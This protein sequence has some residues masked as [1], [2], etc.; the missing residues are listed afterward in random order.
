[1]G[2]NRIFQS[3]QDFFKGFWQQESPR[4][5]LWIPVALGLGIGFYFSLKQEPSLS[6]LFLGIPLFIIKRILPV[7]AG[8]FWLFMGFAA[9]LVKSTWL[10]TPLLLEATPSMALQGTL[11][12]VEI[13]PSDHRLLLKN[14]HDAQGR[15]L[16]LE[17]IRVSCRGSL[18]HGQGALTPGDRLSL[19]CV[20]LPP[21]G[22]PHPHGY[23]FRR[24]AYFQ[25]IGGVGYVTKPPIKMSTADQST[26]I[27]SWRHGVTSF[28]RTHLQGEGGQVAAALITGDRS[29]LTE[30]T[31]NIF[32]EAGVAHILA[33]SGLHLSLVAGIF[34]FFLRGLLASIPA[35]AL[36]YDTKKAAAFMAFFGISAYLI[37]CGASLPAMRS[38]LMTSLILVGVFLDRFAL[39][40]RNVAL[41]ATFLLLI[42][43]EALLS[44]SF[45]LSFAAVI[46]LILGYEALYPWLQRWIG[47]KPWW[48]KKTMVYVLG[49]VLSTVLCTLAT[50]PYV[51]Y[52]F[53]RFSIHTLPANL[54]IIPLMSFFVMPGL[55]VFLLLAP[56][57]NVSY[58]TTVLSKLLNGMIDICHIIT[59]WQ[60]T[61]MPIK[62]MSTFSLGLI[63]LG[64]L[65]FLLIRHPLRLGG[66]FLI[67]WGLVSW[68]ASPMPTVFVAKE[69]K[70]IGWCDLR[71]HLWVSS[72]QSQRYARQSWMR[73]CGK[74]EVKKDPFLLEH[75]PKDI[76]QDVKKYLVQ[77]SEAAYLWVLPKG[78]HW[79]TSPDG[80]ARRPWSDAPMLKDTL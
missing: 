55:V 31:K 7:C 63:T 72:L 27:A 67:S 2:R 53:H 50:T 52:T 38:Y 51:I 70:F 61:S 10:S 12:S 40:A 3:I 75:F 42:W 18:C 66:I 56:F 39:S 73:Y 22:P 62:A 57:V 26:L 77:S 5:V 24:Y 54:M 47:L 6:W 28:L 71:G 13:R 4:G 29:G 58:L 8:F 30:T 69:G 45:Q 46:L 20:L 9:A 79:E 65:G 64:A 15:P 60:G 1:M 44:P 34:F 14:L 37:L 80:Q 36:R 43:P 74:E 49:I 78:R 17:K 41:A 33:I 32:A 25:G 35:F 68:W 11:E 59:Q 19:S 21:P 23:D 48:G 16:P 76:R